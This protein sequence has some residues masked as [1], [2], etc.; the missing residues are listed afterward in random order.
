VDV[1][2]CLKSVLTSSGR[3]AAHISHILRLDPN[4]GPV[5]RFRACIAP[6]KLP[7]EPCAQDNSTALTRS[8]APP[9]CHA[10]EDMYRVCYVA[11]S[12]SVYVMLPP[13]HLS[14]VDRSIFLLSL[15]MTGID[16]SIGTWNALNLL[17]VFDACRRVLRMPHRVPVRGCRPA[18]R[19]PRARGRS[20]SNAQACLA[21]SSDIR[22][23]AD[24]SELWPSER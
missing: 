18:A 1:T 24:K 14:F 11:P 16:L 4:S 10:H 3:C 23:L 6:E 9:R 20:R 22:A 13:H 17:R 21:Y 2:W 5:F 19:A 15:C 7:F 8:V 12:C